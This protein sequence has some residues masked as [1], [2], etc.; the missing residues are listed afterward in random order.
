MPKVTPVTL[1]QLIQ[2]YDVFFID[3]FGVLRDDAGPYEGSIAALAELASAGRQVVILSNSGRSGEYNSERLV[4]LGFAPG[5]F[6]F[7]VTSGDVAFDILSRPGNSIRQKARCFTISSG[8]DSNLA[9]RLGLVSVKEASEAEIVIISG[10][11]A[12]HISMDDYL[13]ML[14]PAA[15]KVVPCYCTNPDTHKLSNG[16]NLPGAGTI[17]K[18]YEGMGGHVTWFGKPYPEIYEHALKLVGVTDR[19]RVACIGDSIDHDILGAK[20][21]GLDSVLVRTGI[22]AAVSDEQIEKLCENARAYPTNVL[23]HFAF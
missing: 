9:D 21:A 5:S 7:F 18:L 13:E 4:K 11:E 2:K 15:E 3:Q 20:S 14:R 6:D 23:Q 16:S 10:S 12:E 17:A 22:L 1:P 19:R 8:G